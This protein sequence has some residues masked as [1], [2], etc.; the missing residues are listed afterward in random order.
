[1]TLEAARRRRAVILSADVNED[2]RFLEGD[3]TE[4][5]KVL[6]AHYDAATTLIEQHR[7][8]LLNSPEDGIMAEFA[9]VVDAVR[10]AVA[11]QKM[12]KARNAQL[13]EDHK[14]T[15][16]IGIHKGNVIAK[17][18]RLYG[19]SVNVVVRLERLAGP[20]GICVSN[21]VYDGIQGKV[22]FRYEWVGEKTFENKFKFPAAYRVLMDTD[23]LSLK[24][25]PKEKVDPKEKLVQME[26]ILNKAHQRR[27]NRSKKRLYRQLRNYLIVNT[28]LLIVNIITYRGYWWIIWPAIV[29]GLVI[30]LRLKRTGL[31]ASEGSAIAEARALL[32]SDQAPTP[33]RDPR[34]IIIQFDPE[35]EENNQTAI[36]IIKIPVQALKAGLKISSFIPDHVKDQV[37]EV[38]HTRSVDGDSSLKSEEIDVFVVSLS[39]ST[40]A[41]ELD[42]AK[43]A[44]SV[45]NPAETTSD[46]S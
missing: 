20:D 30:L 4:I 31:A 9:D 28:F 44:I 12:L 36:D 21:T 24:N 3:E 46:D 45:V 25:L 19:D 39:G 10:G 27:K 5:L 8:R 18:N 22:P 23:E 2:N 16:Q 33:M 38:L 14:M 41:T 42:G 15:F 1:M 29:W 26:D 32:P 34:Q 13:P 43:I 35:D 11:I 17:E 40:V 37:L 7:G 6:A